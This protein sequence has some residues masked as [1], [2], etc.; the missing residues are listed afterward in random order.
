[1]TNLKSLRW[2]ILIA[3]FS[4][5]NMVFA[6]DETTS[7]TK[8]YSSNSD[9]RGVTRWRTTSGATSFNIESRGKIEV[10]DDDKDIKS[11]SEDGYLEISKTVFGS[12]RGIIIESLGGGKLK[13]EYYESRTKMDWEPAGKA[14]LG[15]ILPE[16]LRS[17][18]IAAESR[19]DRFFK[20]G[21]ANAVLGEIG[22]M[23]SIK[24]GIDLR[25]SCQFHCICK[26]ELF[27]F[28]M[29]S[30]DEEFDLKK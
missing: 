30:F 3:T 19:V 29:I 27:Y 20:Q 22:E 8:E 17:T 18:T 11:M 2:I 6:Q 14:W 5:V 21:G 9:G 24:N 4:H 1:M 7:S 25:I 28:L 26:V 12:K 16:V 15:E 13:K 23:E 10:T